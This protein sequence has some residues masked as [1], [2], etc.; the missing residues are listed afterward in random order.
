MTKSE[1]I[2]R[3]REMM[4][5]SNVFS[6]IWLVVFFGVLIGNIPVAT[7]I[8]HHHSAKWIQIL[9]VCW[10]FGFMFGNLALVVWIGRRQN[11][12]LGLLC[13][14]CDKPLVRATA[15][16]AVATGRCGHCGE[17]VF[18]PSAEANPI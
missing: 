18:D 6:G 13:P 14:V 15:Q 7:W 9:F 4:R 5:W 11:R 16:I 2:A 12:K 8:D 17:A 10:F 3:Q 1:F